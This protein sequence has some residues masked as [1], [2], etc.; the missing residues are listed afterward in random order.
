MFLRDAYSLFFPNKSYWGF[1]YLGDTLSYWAEN[2]TIIC[3]I[4]AENLVQW[5][6]CIYINIK[7][8][9]IPKYILIYTCILLV[10]TAKY[11]SYLFNRTIKL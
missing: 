9:I 3:R 11:Q 8:V 4:A 7:K 5:S 2:G 10:C 6:I 1:E